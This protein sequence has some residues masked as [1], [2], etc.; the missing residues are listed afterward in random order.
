MTGRTA[1]TDE[2]SDFDPDE[3]DGSVSSP[4]RPVQNEAA[5]DTTSPE[6]PASP[7]KAEAKAAL[8]RP[9][10]PDPVQESSASV[11]APASPVEPASPVKP[12]SPE[13]PEV[14]AARTQAAG[15]H[16]AAASSMAPQK[17]ADISIPGDL[18]PEQES[19][20]AEQAA[21]PPAGDM[22]VEGTANMLA[23]RCACLLLH[24]CHVKVLHHKHGRQR[25]EVATCKK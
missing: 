22:I 10:S 24:T 17:S 13:R 1:A 16:Q 20:K 11:Q 5:R 21:E 15:L 6:R 12:A 3:D 14:H 18:S 25:A 2:E 9:A 19:H 8:R 7:Q 23:G 4:R